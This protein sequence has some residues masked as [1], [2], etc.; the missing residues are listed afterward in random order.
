MRV[1]IDVGGYLGH[2]TLA[3]LD[4]IFGF[5][6]IYCFE[7]VPELAR[8]LRNIND[9]KVTIVQACLSNRNGSTPVHHAGT[10]AGTMFADGPV[11]GEGGADIMAAMISAAVFA[12]M[13]LAS[14]DFVRIKLNC[15]GAEVDIIESLLDAQCEA[16]L[17]NALIDFDAHKIPSLSFRLT[18]IIERLS[19]L[20]INYLTPPQCQY[21]MVNNYG[22]VR[23]YLL[24][25]GAQLEGFHRRWMSLLYN[26]KCAFDGELNGYHKMRLLRWMPFLR[27]LQRSHGSLR[28]P[29]AG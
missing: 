22:A 13:F 5:D 23:N 28:E 11:Y 16:I 15:E 9:P 1:F 10:L 17:V 24:C 29:G 14:A 2:S 26:I 18:K 27:V 7:P 12:E 8:R 25:S 4:P 6:R 19:N 3:A 20:G 21:G